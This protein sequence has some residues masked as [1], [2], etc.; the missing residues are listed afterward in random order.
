MRRSG[1][2]IVHRSNSIPLGL[3]PT[4]GMNFSRPFEVVDAGP[5][6]IVGR[7]LEA[8]RPQALRFQPI[9]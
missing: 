3:W 2:N 6:D 9:A 7:Q 5:E 8:Q 4:A 1:R